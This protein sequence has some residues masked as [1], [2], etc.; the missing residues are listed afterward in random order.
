MVPPI[1]PQYLSL[2][3][4]T[5]GGFAFGGN[6]GHL[7]FWSYV[8]DQLEA[9]EI[10][11]AVLFVAYP[12]M[13]W[14]VFPIQFQE[15]V[16]AIRHVLEKCNRSPSEVIIGGDSA[17]GNL[18][19]AA[20]LHAIHP[21]DLAAPLPK[22]SIT[23]KLRAL[24][25]VSPWVSFDTSIPSFQRNRGKDYIDADCEK[26]WSDM[27]VGEDLP[28]PYNE[29]ALAFAP[30][31]K[32]LPVQDVLVTAGSDESLIDGISKW[33]KDLEVSNLVVRIPKPRLTCH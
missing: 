19:A 20:L 32:D 6:E 21:S 29:P 31:W 1:T 3:S 2:T 27:Y 22:V 4:L 26:R 14:T 30:D 24:V 25:L 7:R 15:A 9:H 17:G 8:R 18:A 33:V 13:P 12:L 28:S 23:E 16:Y 10:F 11:V 5:G